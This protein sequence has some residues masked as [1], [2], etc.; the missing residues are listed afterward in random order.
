MTDFGRGRLLA[1]IAA[2]PHALLT[3]TDVATLW[4]V[5]E[6]SVTRWRKIGRLPSSLQT[7]GGQHRW[8]ARDLA[9]Y[10]GII[11]GGDA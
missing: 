2:D 10:F 5:S 11:Y 3:L 9:P 8:E 1:I 6:K 4:E 7:P